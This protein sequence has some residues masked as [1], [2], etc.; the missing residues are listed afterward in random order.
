MVTYLPE[1]EPATAKPSLEEACCGN[2]SN[3]D[4]NAHPWREAGEDNRG[5]HYVCPVCGA[6]D[7]D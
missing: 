2:P 7:T 1:P 5:T 4:G 6:T 3:L